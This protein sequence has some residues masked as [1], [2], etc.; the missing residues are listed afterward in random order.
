MTSRGEA[1]NESLRH[2]TVLEE[3]H[4]ILRSNSSSSSPEMGG[5]LAAK[6]VEMLAN[7]I[8]EM[9]TY[10]EAFVIVDQAP[11]LLDTSVIRNTNTKIIMRL[12]DQSDRE[13]VGK[14]ANLNNEQILELARLQRGIAA[15][16]Q[17]EWIEPVLCHVDRHTKASDVSAIA[18]LSAS[19]CIPNE[20]ESLSENEQRY[21]NTCIYDP[22]YLA[23]QSDISFVDCIAKLDTTRL[24]KGQLIIYATTPFEALK[25][26]YE[27]TAFS[28]FAIDEIAK[29]RMPDGCTWDDVLEEWL[30]AYQF[31]PDARLERQSQEWRLFSQTMLAQ[32]ILWT[33]RNLKEPARTVTAEKL[34]NSRVL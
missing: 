14:A 33:S 7:C 34:W 22:R 4:N 15:V 16:Y 31:M 3:A 23:R 21:V 17:N 19:T 24:N 2:I 6:S 29:R 10:G 27:K 30:T 11:G 9:R 5:G 32:A 28:W 1:E 20:T 25:D 8:A 18:P 12:P 26:V 13:L